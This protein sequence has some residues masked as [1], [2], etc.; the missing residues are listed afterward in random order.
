MASGIVRSTT[1]RTI[2]Q[3]SAVNGHHLTVADV[4]RFA[5]LLREAGVPE[6]QMVDVDSSFETLHKIGLRVV[7]DSK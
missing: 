6:K 3:R 4:L 2:V 1:N 5:E 7:W